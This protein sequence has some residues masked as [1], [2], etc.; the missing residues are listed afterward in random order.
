M[1]STAKQL[2]A[3]LAASYIKHGV[4]Q[5]TKTQFLDCLEDLGYALEA[6]SCF[7]YHNT[8]NKIPY[9]ARALYYVEKDTGLSAFNVNA[10][11]DDNFRA[12]QAMR[13]E[14][15]V[16]NNNRIWEL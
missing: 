5:L 16:F 13:R 2:T 3:A 14:C 10:R 7:N 9:L 6:D 12:L 8:A 11:R 15:F 4:K 1:N